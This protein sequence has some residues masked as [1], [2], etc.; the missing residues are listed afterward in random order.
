MQSHQ[1]M[2]EMTDFNE[3]LVHMKI[4]NIVNPNR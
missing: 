4:E 2:E 1:P 3:K